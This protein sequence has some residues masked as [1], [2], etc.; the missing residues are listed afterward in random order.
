MANKVI[1][2]YSNFSKN[3]TGVYLEKKS[4]NFF[5]SKVTLGAGIKISEPGQEE[6]E[7]KNLDSAHL[8]KKYNLVPVSLLH[9]LAVSRFE[10]KEMSVS[11]ITRTCKLCFFLL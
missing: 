2:P 9:W 4:I 1:I 10:G 6:E 5:K 3:K 8:E 11:S 7:T